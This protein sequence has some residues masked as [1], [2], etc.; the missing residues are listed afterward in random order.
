MTRKVVVERDDAGSTLDYNEL[1]FNEFVVPAL[2]LENL[3]LYFHIVSFFVYNINIQ[4]FL[5][6]FVKMRKYFV[7]NY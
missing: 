7:K 3:N 5:I 2:S 4:N 6:L 1:A